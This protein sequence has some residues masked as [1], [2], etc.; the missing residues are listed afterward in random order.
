MTPM[1]SDDRPVIAHVLH[2][3]YLAGAEVLAAELARRLTDRYRFIFLCLDEVGPLGHKLTGEGFK[4]VDLRRRPGIDFAVARRLRRATRR[5]GVDLIHAHQYTPFFYA[6]LSRCG[7]A[8]SQPR[9]LFTEHGRHYP[10][11]RSLKRMVANRWLLKPTDRVSAVGG[12]IQR[13]LIDN[14]GIRPDRHPVRVIL[15]G[16][17]PASY[18]PPTAE[19]RRDARARMGLT[20]QDLVVL[21]VARFHP[22]KDH[23]TALAAFARV[24]EQEPA[25]RL[26][27][28][29]DGEDWL[30]RQQQARQLGIDSRVRFLGVRDDVP[31][32]LPGADVF[33]LSSLSEGIS[34]TLLEAMAAHLPIVATD[35]GGNAEV[36]EHAATG[37]LSQRGDAA[38][39]ANNLLILLRD[40]ATRQRLGD[41]SHARLLARFTQARMHAEY[42]HVYESMLP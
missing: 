13:A 16:I 8:A 23:T 12:F 34:V 20:P 42:A 35:V 17:D 19:H 14:E 21:Q 24:A 6:A 29:G 7:G 37:L 25:A 31:A 36:V 11:R 10:D 15:N 22:V 32:L 4:V 40:A 2:R 41:A 28:V 5:Y 30:A 9:L 33:L 1:A 27:L 38:A 39:M 18:P 26:V 3:L